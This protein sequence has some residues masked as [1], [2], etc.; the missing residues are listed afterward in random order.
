LSLDEIGDF[1]VSSAVAVAA[2]PEAK[3]S[4]RTF[5]Q[6]AEY[7]D[8]FISMI[9][10]AGSG[11]AVLDPQLRIRENNVAFSRQCGHPSF[12]LRDTCFTDL[13]HPHVRQHI[14]RQFECLVQGSRKRFVE[15]LAVLHHASDAITGTLTGIGVQCD[16]GRLKTIVVIVNRDGSDDERRSSVQPKRTLTEINARILEGVATGATTVQLAARLYLSRQGI[17][18]HVGS[19]MR[20]FKVPNRVALVSKAYSMGVFAVGSWPPKVVGDHIQP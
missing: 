2:Y 6:G 5:L 4:D 16:A 12:D 7:R 15:R 17:E 10:R 18:Y 14:V 8:I 11:F 3:S 9:E 1:F 20:Q 13:L 19:M